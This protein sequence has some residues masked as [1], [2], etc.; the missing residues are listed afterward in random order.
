MDDFT[1]QLPDEAPPE[2]AAIATL[3]QGLHGLL[4]SM[5]ELHTQLAALR[6]QHEALHKRVDE[7]A[8]TGARKRRA[9]PGIPW[10]LRWAELDHTGASQAWVWL[11]GWVAWLVERY[12]LVEELPSC[13][14][15]HPALVEELTA[16]AA[17]WY[18]AY[19]E[20]A[21]AAAPLAWHE[22]FTRARMRLREWD[23]YTRCRNGTHTTRQLDLDWPDT[24]RAGAYDIAEADVAHRPPP[25]HHRR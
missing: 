24:W 3:G 23:D 8:G 16:L 10:P 9:P 12:Q 7:Q 20:T 13:W 11:I 2:M 22:R 15:Q 4:A 21:D 5:T 14:P 18:A 1:Y 6:E 17:G 19:D 25:P